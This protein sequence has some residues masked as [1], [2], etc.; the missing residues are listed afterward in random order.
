MSMTPEET[1]P[2]KDLGKGPNPYPYG[3]WQWHEHECA[4]RYRQEAFLLPFKVAGLVLFAI[5]AVAYGIWGFA[6]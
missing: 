3:A 5:F 2:P 1:W 6:T 4:A